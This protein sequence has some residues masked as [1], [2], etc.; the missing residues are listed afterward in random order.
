[1]LRWIR[2]TPSDHPLEHK[3]DARQLLSDLP[4][5]GPFRAL[6]E[7]SSYLDAVKTADKLKPIR[8]FE[9]VGASFTGVTVI[10]TVAIF[11]AAV[12]SKTRNVKLSGPL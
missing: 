12:P 1:M 3:D 8:V 10:E 7:L 11:E 5:K 6:E 9:I 4:D 2:G